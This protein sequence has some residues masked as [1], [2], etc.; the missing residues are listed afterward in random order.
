MTAEAKA[1]YLAVLEKQRRLIKGLNNDPEMD[2][3]V[4]CWQIYQINLEE[5]RVKLM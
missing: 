2:E 1:H 4:I 5:E 3:S